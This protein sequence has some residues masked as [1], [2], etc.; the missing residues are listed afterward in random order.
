PF[1]FRRAGLVVGVLRL[2]R[3]SRLALVFGKFRRPSRPR[4]SISQ[5]A[6]L[7]IELTFG[8]RATWGRSFVASVRLHDHRGALLSHLP[9][10]PAPPTSCELLDVSELLFSGYS[11]KREQREHHGKEQNHMHPHR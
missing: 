7:K 10:D 5:L 3:E 11:T 4:R 2:H 1:V 9:R 6:V 8:R